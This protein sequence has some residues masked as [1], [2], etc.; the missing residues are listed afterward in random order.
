L[1]Q[2]DEALRW[3]GESETAA[4]SE[5]MSETTEN[6]VTKLRALLK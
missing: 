6:Q 4:K 1:G 3:K 2:H 5:W